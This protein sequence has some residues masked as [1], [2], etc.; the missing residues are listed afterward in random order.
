MG[1]FLLFDQK[2]VQAGPD[3]RS[4]V[5]GR[6]LEDPGGHCPQYAHKISVCRGDG[7]PGT[8][9]NPEKTEEKEEQL[10]FPRKEMRDVIDKRRFSG[11]G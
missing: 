9:Q 1:S 11:S 5:Q 7:V 8:G 6:G 3:L 4:G 10:R 2:I